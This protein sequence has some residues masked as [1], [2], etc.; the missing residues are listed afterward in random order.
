MDVLEGKS[1][2]LFGQNWIRLNQSEIY[3]IGLGVEEIKAK[4]QSV[5][6]T[7]IGSLKR[8]QAILQ[9]ILM[10]HQNFSVPYALK[11]VIEKNLESLELISM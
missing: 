1:P 4:L 10:P 8:L 6:S 2:S 5:F 3:H 9:I 11:S 7:Q